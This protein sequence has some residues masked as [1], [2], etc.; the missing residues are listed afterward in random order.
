MDLYEILGIAKNATIEEIKKAYRKLSQECHPDKPTGSHDKFVA[1]VQ[2]YEVLKNPQQREHYDNTGTFGGKEAASPETIA[3]NMLQNAL[4]SIID[5]YGA[6]LKYVDVIDEVNSKLDEG[7]ANSKDK[8][9]QAEARLVDL[10]D[11]RARTSH[12]D[13]I[14]LIGGLIDNNIKSAQGEITFMEKNIQGLKKAKEILK[15]QGFRFDEK[16]PEEKPILGNFMVFNEF[17]PG[18]NFDGI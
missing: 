5:Y 11:L 16:P 13:E 9:Q 3:I 17:K 8:I 15:T 1:I 18:G 6:R 4:K 14:D 10:N 2:A 12:T 7:I